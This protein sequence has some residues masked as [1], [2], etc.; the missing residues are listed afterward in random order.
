MAAKYLR[1][2]NNL[3]PTP[4]VMKQGSEQ[5]RAERSRPGPTRVA[6]TRMPEAHQA[7]ADTACTECADMAHPAMQTRHSH[8]KNAKHADGRGHEDDHHAVRKLKGM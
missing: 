1:G 3:N 8:P 2:D 6:G 4:M 5:A 7:P